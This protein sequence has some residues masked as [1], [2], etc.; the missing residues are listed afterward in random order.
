VG[1][2]HGSVANKIVRTLKACNFNSTLS[3]SRGINRLAIRWRGHRLLNSS[4]DGD[5]VHAAGVR[6]NSRGQRPRIVINNIVRTLKACNSIRPFQGRLINL[7]FVL[8]GFHPRLLNASPAGTFFHS[9]FTIYDSLIGS[10]YD[11]P[12]PGDAVIDRSAFTSFMT[13]FAEV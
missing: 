2:A 10:I 7:V 8:R 13:S 4:P 3:G 6:L 5:G 9:R 12:D 1:N 11:L